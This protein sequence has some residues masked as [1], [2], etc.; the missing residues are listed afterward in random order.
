MV[1]NDLALGLGNSLLALLD[2]GVEELFHLAA[3]GADE[4]IVVLAFVQFVNG[5]AALEVAAAQ[6]AG[7]LKLRQHAVHRGQADV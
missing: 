2:L 3:G 7:L 5:L 4:V 1:L 6:N